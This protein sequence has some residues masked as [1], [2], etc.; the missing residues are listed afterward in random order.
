MITQPLTQLSSVLGWTHVGTAGSMRMWVGGGWTD[1]DGL[2][3]LSATRRSTLA[4]RLDHVRGGSGSGSRACSC[5][6]PRNAVDD[7]AGI[8]GGAVTIVLGAGL[9]GKLLP[10]WLPPSGRTPP[11]S[12]GWHQSATRG[13]GRRRELWRRCRRSPLPRGW[14]TP[15]PPRVAAAKLM[16]MLCRVEAAPDIGSI[17]HLA[18]L[19]SLFPLWCPAKAL[20]TTGRVGHLPPH[21]LAEHRQS[22]IGGVPH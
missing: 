3:G 10:T 7:G 12:G 16:L 15:H 4:G 19:C 17:L 5:F 22:S 20:P 11:D 8:T 13:S 21:L 18:P 6:L 1:R 9:V 14:V 2:R